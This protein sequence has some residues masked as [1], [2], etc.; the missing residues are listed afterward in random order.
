VARVRDGD[1]VAIGGCLFSRTPMALVHEIIRLRRTRLTLCRNLMCY[2]G[3]LVVVAGGAQRV[4]TSWMGI[5]LPWGLSKIVRQYV[6]SG[7]LLF[8]EWSHLALGLRF[9][10]GSA[11]V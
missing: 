4:V 10:I 6:E 1:V 7:K 9:Q 3:E 11:H 5:G 2:E 8:E